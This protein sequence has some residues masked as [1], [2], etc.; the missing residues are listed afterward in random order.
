MNN[1]IFFTIS[2][3][4]AASCI[5]LSTVIYIFYKYYSNYKK[6]KVIKQLLEQQHDDT[7]L[8]K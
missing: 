5:L 3:Y 2:A 1:F 7:S 6:L 8:G 4:I